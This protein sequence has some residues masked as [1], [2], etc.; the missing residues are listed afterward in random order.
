[1]TIIVGLSLFSLI[2]LS[3]SIAQNSARKVLL[4]SHE[5]TVNQISEFCDNMEKA[6]Y[7]VAYSQT[8]QDFFTDTLHEQRLL[9]YGSAVRSVFSNTFVFNQYLIGIS[10]YDLQGNYLMSTGSTLLETDPLSSK[11]LGITSSAYSGAQQNSNANISQFI[12]VYPIYQMNKSSALL[13]AKI[14]FV[15]FT[16]NAEFFKSLFKQSEYYDD[17]SIFSIGC[18]QT[19][20][21]R[22]QGRLTTKH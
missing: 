21:D 11:Y 19:A 9:D 12:L 3:Y 2:T 10:L 18:R 22:Q 13:E 7:S 16:L 20:D 14:G 6:A 4:K 15:V 5:L 17:T 8:I 1:M